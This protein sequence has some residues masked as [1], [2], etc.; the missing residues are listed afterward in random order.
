MVETVLSSCP[1]LLY[2]DD[3]HRNIPFAKRF[4][5]VEGNL[6]APFNETEPAITLW[7]KQNQMKEWLTSPALGE[8]IW[9]DDKVWIGE[10]ESK[11]PSPTHFQLICHGL[12]T[13]PYEVTQWA[14][15]QLHKRQMRIEVMGDKADEGK[16]EFDKEN[17]SEL[18]EKENDPSDAEETH[19]LS[20]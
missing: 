11:F 19:L 8:N 2:A 4:I 18:D 9:S 17:G 16:D 3:L 12:F 14:Q 1:D 6:D 13:E 15:K 10:G 5:E 7:I 20:L